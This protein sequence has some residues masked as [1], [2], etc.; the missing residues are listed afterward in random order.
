MIAAAQPTDER[1]D[2]LYEQIGRLEPIDRSI[3]LLQLDGFSY[4][5]IADLIGI[6]QS[7]VG[8]RIHR[9]KRHLVNQS[10]ELNH[11]GV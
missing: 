9:I 7:H 6:S 3:C 4:A 10:Q 2:W 11:H 8:V 1:L 5:E